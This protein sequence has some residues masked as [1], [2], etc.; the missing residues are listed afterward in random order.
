MHESMVRIEKLLKAQGLDWVDFARLL[1]VQKQH[2][3]NWKNR[4]ISKNKAIEAAQK[5][6]TPVDLIL[7]DEAYGAVAI[8]AKSKVSASGSTKEVPL[9]YLLLSASPKAQQIINNIIALDSSGALDDTYLDMLQ[10]ML[11]SIP[12]E[13]NRS[14]KAFRDYE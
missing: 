8:Q 6:D 7:C 12:K 9:E 4:G 2:I 11:D 1:G 10:S 5:L 3:N 14:A 13:P